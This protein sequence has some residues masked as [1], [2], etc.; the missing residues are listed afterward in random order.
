MKVSGFGGIGEDLMSVRAVLYGKEV[1]V[2]NSIEALPIIC[3]KLHRSKSAKKNKRARERV[4]DLVTTFDIETTKVKNIAD[5]TREHG[6]YSHFNYCFHWQYCFDGVIICGRHIEEFF[7][8]QREISEYINSN[9]DSNHIIY[10]YVHNLAY[11]YNNLAEYFVTNCENPEKDLFFRDRTHPLFIK[12]G[13]IEYRCSYQLTHK[14]LATLSQEIGLE[15]GGDFDYAIQRHSNTPLTDNELEYCLRDVFNL[16]L[17]LEHEYVRYSYSINKIPHLCYMPLTQTGYVR[18]DIRE[19]WSNTD[20]GINRLRLTEMDEAEYLMCNK[21]FRGGDTNA[22]VKYIGQKLK[23]I[24]HRDFTSAYPSVMC[25][26]KFPLRKWI[27]IEGDI[28]TVYDYM[29]RD[30]AVICTYQLSNIRLRKQRS[31]YIASSKCDYISNDCCIANGRVMYCGGALVLT[32][33]EVDFSIICDCYTFNID[34]VCNIMVA[35][36]GYLPTELVKVILKYFSIKTT[37]KG[38]A[39]QKDEYDLAKQKLN[40][41]YGCS[42]TALKHAETTIDV[43]TLEANTSQ[44]EY[45]KSN[46]MPYQWAAYIT[47]YV[48]RN[49]HHFKRLLGNDYIYCD[50]DSIFYKSTGEFEKA[51][52]VY[53]ENIKKRLHELGNEIGDIDLVIPTAPNGKKQYLGL[54]LADDDYKID[55]FMTAGAKRYITE[56]DG[57]VNM[58]VSGLP[59]AKATKD[60]KLGGNAQ[61]LSDTYGSVYNAFE[62][63]C[64][65]ESISIPYTE[66]YGKLSHYVERGYF[67]GAINDGI[68][69]EHV[70]ARS[71]MVLYSVDNTLSLEH[72]LLNYMFALNGAFDTHNT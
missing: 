22:N 20:K 42:A 17:W 26:E 50:T 15:K 63:M 60:G 45:K 41:I 28:S 55:Y 71:S 61:I 43:A 34:S 38:V 68:T 13:C 57:I 65:G 72:N 44:G 36:K 64:N 18:Y 51:V 1:T 58:T 7:K 33:T 32:C 10:C 31:G 59:H 39:D 12:N 62:K 54:F 21:A 67:K 46:V 14:T 24:S 4:F 3:Y 70:E 5:G 9:F 53:N 2:Y 19:M 48:R 69:I 23:D 52:E 35:K 40:G 37:L 66:E 16:A 27:K 30:W 11:E 29:T 6:I 47:A 49:L 56:V 25:L 8:L